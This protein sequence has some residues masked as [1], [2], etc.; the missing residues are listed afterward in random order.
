ME[1]EHL[2]II[3]DNVSSYSDTSLYSLRDDITKRIA[4]MQDIGG[5]LLELLS[6]VDAEIE[7]RK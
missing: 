2:D 3:M 1:L 4:H 7:R 6:V 5:T